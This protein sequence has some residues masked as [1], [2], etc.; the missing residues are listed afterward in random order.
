[1]RHSALAF[2][3]MLTLAALPTLA[4]GQEPGEQAPLAPPRFIGR[5]FISSN[6]PT[7]PSGI[8]GVDPNN[9]TL[10]KVFDRADAF[11]RFS[12]DGSRVAFSW[13]D[14]TVRPFKMVDLRVADITARAE[15]VKVF[16][17]IATARGWSGDGKQILVMARSPGGEV[18][19]WRVAADNSRRERLPIDVA[20]ERV[21]DW[22]PDGRWILTFSQRK[23]PDRP[24]YLMHADGTGQ[25]V[26]LAASNP[27]PG[28]GG[29]LLRGRFSPDSRHVFFVH[30]VEEEFVDPPPIKTSA[31]LVLDVDE[32]RPR[33]ILERTKGDHIQSALCSP[34]GKAIAVLV[35]DGPNKTIRDATM[36]H[37]EIVDIDGRLLQTIRSPT[38]S[39]VHNMI[40]WR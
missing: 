38:L 26:L 7:D 6:N 37:L 31:V 36:T 39:T 3:G 2:T 19:L 20:T 27:V 12:T 15:P 13:F 10:Q 8:I 25:R 1:M 30:H 18:Q 5:I 4:L 28:L 22:S 33:R 34:D 9:K 40:D 14:T 16:E 23:L 17:G 29:H 24:V 35:I 21:Q 32:G 11:A